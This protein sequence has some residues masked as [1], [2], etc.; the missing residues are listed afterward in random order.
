MVKLPRIWGLFKF[1][2]WKWYVQSPQLRRDFQCTVI[3]LLQTV[4]NRFTCYYVY[5]KLFYCCI[6][7]SVLLLIATILF[8]LFRFL[9][10][11]DNALRNVSLN[12][13]FLKYYLRFHYFPKMLVLLVI[14]FTIKLYA[15]ANILKNIIKTNLTLMVFIQ[16]TIYLNKEWGICN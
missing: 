11:F 6:A 8:L 4:S 5:L 13:W 14:P 1:D 10:S 16:E 9:S 12:I 2:C 15:Q 3:S 7:S